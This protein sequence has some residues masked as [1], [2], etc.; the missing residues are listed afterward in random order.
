MGEIPVGFLQEVLIELGVWDSF[1]QEAL[2]GLMSLC[3]VLGQPLTL[4]SHSKELGQALG[5][6]WGSGRIR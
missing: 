2:I 3:V 4:L 1:L 6:F 5:R